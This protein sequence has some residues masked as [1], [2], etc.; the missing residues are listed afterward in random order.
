MK[1]RSI[2]STASLLTL[3]A[4][5]GDDSPSIEELEAAQAGVSNNSELENSDN[6]ISSL[7]SAKKICAIKLSQVFGGSPN[8]PVVQQGCDCI[9]SKVP[10]ADMK[11]KGVLEAN[12]TVT[13][14]CIG[15]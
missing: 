6:E 4:C 2:I 10:L 15:N 11:S 8:S 14:Q 1:L 9:V 5:S 7:E 3:V 13:N 12:K